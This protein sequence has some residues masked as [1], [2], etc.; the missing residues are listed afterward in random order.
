M[1]KRSKTVAMA[2][3]G[4]A[5]F[6]L[7]GCREEEVD[8]QAFPDVESCHAAAQGG[9]LTVD[10]CDQAFAEAQK[11][12]VETAPRYD[13]R[14]VCEEQH[15]AGACGSE[16]AQTGGGSGGIFMPLLTGYLIGSLLSGRAG[17]AG[18]QPMYRTADGRFTTP[19]G[20]NTYSSNQGRTKLGTSA[21]ARPPTTVGQPPMSRATVQSRGGFGASS[22]TGSGFGG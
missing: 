15:G 19:G 4:A 20:G 12:H 1:T 10:Q 7:A 21:F 5:A 3:V 6:A 2:I 9:Q 14:E 13:S 22:R 8:A 16:V 18:A 11:L 17:M